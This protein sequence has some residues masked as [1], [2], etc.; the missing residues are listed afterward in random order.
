MAITRTFKSNKDIYGNG[1]YGY[2]EDGQ[3]VLGEEWPHEGGITYR[4]SYSDAKKHLE[5]LKAKAPRLYNDIEKY[6]TLHDP[7]VVEADRDY[8]NKKIAEA[9]EVMWRVKIF[10]EGGVSHT[11]CMRSAN[12]DALIKQLMP[13]T[14]TVITLPTCEA[15]TFVVRSNKIC[16]IEIMKV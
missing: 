6:Y 5:G 8:I 3:L 12:E 4:G 9:T 1:Y 15:S 10:I 14:P 7:D 2:I 13:A 16:A 11:C